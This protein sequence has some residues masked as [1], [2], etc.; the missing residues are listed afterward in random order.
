MKLKHLILIE[1]V[2]FWVIL[3]AIKRELELFTL[4]YY[5]YFAISIFY[6]VVLIKEVKTENLVVKRLLAG[7]GTSLRLWASKSLQNESRT[8]F[9]LLLLFQ[10]FIYI[11]L[12]PHQQCHQDPLV[13][14]NCR[15]LFVYIVVVGN[16]YSQTHRVNGGV[17]G[18][19]V[20]VF[21]YSSITR[22]SILQL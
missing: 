18:T 22:S 12:V 20:H 2:L 1:F 7:G 11:F 17:R 6:Y 5:L 13:W 4:L 8:E 9:F 19:C 14:Y 15:P 16:V 10:L 21:W 3:L